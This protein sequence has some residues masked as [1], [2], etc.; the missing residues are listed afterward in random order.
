MYLVEAFVCEDAVKWDKMSN[1][2][3]GSVSATKCALYTLYG[4]S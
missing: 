2:L 1:I 4:S 3:E